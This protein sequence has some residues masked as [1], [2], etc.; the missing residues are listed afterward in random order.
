MHV[1]FWIRFAASPEGDPGIPAGGQDTPQGEGE[2]EGSEPG[3]GS[4]QEGAK[5]FSKALKKRVAEIEAKYADYEDLKKKAEAYD[6]SQAD[7]QSETEKLL[8]RIT[9]LEEAAKE[10]DAAIERG[11]T[12]AK[13][14]KETGVDRDIL[15]LLAPQSADELAQ[16]AQLLAD[17]VG[18]AGEKKPSLPRAPRGKAT[19]DHRGGGGETA[20]DYLR[21]AYTS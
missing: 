12:L 15:E 14:S 11:K 16:A 3:E 8:A 7:A 1:P 17:W 2:E 19:A 21:D 13:V 10:K 20:M 9:A 18:K 4:G 5:A 6:A